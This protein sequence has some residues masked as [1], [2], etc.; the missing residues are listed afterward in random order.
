MVGDD[1]TGKTNAAVCMRI[2]WC[3][4]ALGIFVLG[5]SNPKD[6]RPYCDV[7]HLSGMT[8][9]SV[10]LKEWGRFKSTAFVISVHDELKSKLTETFGKDRV[11][12]TA[13][14]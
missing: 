2:K 7:S 8:T 3:I 6:T 1:S 10:S 12:D 13:S 14:R 5:C 11:R 9:L 4:I